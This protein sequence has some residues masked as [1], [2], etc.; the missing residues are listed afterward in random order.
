MKGSA[1]NQRAQTRASRQCTRRLGA[2][3][4]VPGIEI[5]KLVASAPNMRR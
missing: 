2:I 5:I 1:Q 3:W 4:A